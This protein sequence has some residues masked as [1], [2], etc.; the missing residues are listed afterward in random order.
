M[1]A[2]YLPFNL[3]LRAPAIL[4]VVGGDA[5]S[6]ATLGYIPGGA[7]RGALA[8]RLGDP[9]SREEA[10]SLFQSLVLDGSVCC[11]N[12]YPLDPGGRRTLPAST[13]LRSSR[14]PDR[15]LDLAAFDGQCQATWP[16]ESL[17]VFPWR[18]VSL[19]S[20]QPVGINTEIGSRIHHQRDRH[21][22]RAWT[23]K[24]DGRE[25]PHGAIFTYEYLQPGQTFGGL[26]QVSG[27]DESE[28]RQHINQI[29]EILK[30]PIR[31]G[32]S[33]R[34]GYGGEAEVVWRSVQNREIS[35]EGV[36]ST[37]LCAGDLFRVLLTSHCIV[38][39][40]Q[41]G[42]IDP[43]SLPEVFLSRFGGRVT[44]HRIRW[45]FD[46]VGGF[47]QK[48][49][50]E[51]PQARSVAAG[52]VLLFQA[53]ERIPLDFLLQLEHEGIGER[54]TEGFGRFTFLE[55]PVQQVRVRR[56]TRS[57]VQ[58]PSLAAS[59]LVEFIERRLLQSAVSREIEHLALTVAGSA[60]RIP[61]PSLLGR[62]RVPLRTQPAGAL[63]TLAEWL[64]SGD[65]SLR[66]PAQDQLRRCRINPG[67]GPLSLAVW[68]S[69]LAGEHRWDRL[70]ETLRLTPLAQRNHV[71]SE[72][73]ALQQLK[74]MNDE[75]AV[76]LIDATLAALAKQR[77]LKQA[78]TA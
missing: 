27:A 9:E 25:F 23:E 48:W 16:E 44:L 51:L 62:L 22:G 55:A 50:L 75:I 21:R 71:V 61:T 10:R 34:A 32:R 57:Q 41:T 40:P 70:E 5:N 3:A 35:G 37:D 60:S 15:H 18:Y 46:V 36:I 33:R 77:K 39:N 7:V 76:R 54:R 69:N 72:D 19:T 78:S 30:G 2:K 58:K 56:T 14:E 66:R 8:G 4:N 1:T 47:N 67:T 38:R 74:R 52:S 73:D 65:H 20:A 63:Q 26:I 11:L 12:A 64:G 24:R 28:C 17:S 29:Q 68:L 45:A 6:A 53:E 49:R 31:L 43:A 42:Q 13:S 59:D